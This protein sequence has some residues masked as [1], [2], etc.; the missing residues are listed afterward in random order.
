MRRRNIK[1]LKGKPKTT[2]KTYRKVGSLPLRFKNPF[3][4][5][6][7]KQQ[8]Y[9]TYR[10]PI[11]RTGITSLERADQEKAMKKIEELK[12]AGLYD[13]ESEAWF[14]V[15]FKDYGNVAMFPLDKDLPQGVTNVDAAE[16]YKN[17][18]EQAQAFNAGILST[19]QKQMQDL[20]KIIKKRQM[21]EL[22][23][24]AI[25]YLAE[26]DELDQI[27]EEYQEAVASWY[28]AGFPVRYRKFVNI[29]TNS[30]YPK[31]D[32]V[33][34]LGTE[35]EY[36]EAKELWDKEYGDKVQTRL[37]T[38]R[39]VDRKRMERARKRGIIEREN[40]EN[41]M[42]EYREK[43]REQLGQGSFSKREG[44][45]APFLY[46]LVRP[47]HSMDKMFQQTPE[48][49]IKEIK[50]EQEEMRDDY[51]AQQFEQRGL[52]PPKEMVKRAFPN[53]AF[54]LFNKTQKD[55]AQYTGTI[56]AHPFIFPKR[57]F[58]VKTA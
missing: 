2:N 41:A 58:F 24:K 21:E 25:Q 17:A 46:T 55:P 36:D 42:K 4:T 6:E 51:R 20:Y 1:S 15:S 5:S 52:N 27:P 57:K 54:P 7:R 39:N 19:K 3:L 9:T 45:R 34:K 16:K 8:M 11:I 30:L 40:K 22:K 33:P 23:N 31:K 29:E 43:M 37:I 26:T 10:S 12:N 48:D 53:T 49:R 18:M 56:I 32:A 28:Y 50:D 38:K 35:A 44:W 14:N 47:I 13:P